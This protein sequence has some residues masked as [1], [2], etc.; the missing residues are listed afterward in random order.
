MNAFVF[1]VIGVSGFLLAAVCLVIALVMFVRLDVRSAYGELRE[2]DDRHPGAS[3]GSQGGNGLQ[4]LSDPARRKKRCRMPRKRKVRPEQAGTRS[5]HGP[6]SAMPRSPHGPSSAIH[7]SASTKEQAGAMRPRSLGSRVPSVGS[8]PGSTSPR[9]PAAAASQQVC[10]GVDAPVAH[11]SSDG[12][13]R[14]IAVRAAPVATG[15][16]CGEEET[17]MLTSSPEADAG[18]SRSTCLLVGDEETGPLV[19]EQAYREGR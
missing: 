10:D 3:E 14:D 5:P 16:L 18:E 15:L 13:I 1:M 4:A 9:R 12:A 17:S 2:T 7:P 11:R 6:S 19:G 8:I